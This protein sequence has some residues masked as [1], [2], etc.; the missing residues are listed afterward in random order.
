MD[1]PHAGDGGNTAPGP[2]IRGQVPVISFV[3]AG[4]YENVVDNYHP[5]DGFEFVTVTS[6]IRRHTFALKV[7]NDSMLN[8]HGTPSFPPGIIVVIEPDLEAQIGDFV[9]VK[10]GSDEATF[11]QLV[12]DDGELYLKPLNPAYRT[13]PFPKDGHIVGVLREAIWKFR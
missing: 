5:G 3:Q 11:K 13:K 9:V 4:D 10:N 7:K 8:P 6:P 12:Q 2:D 1:T